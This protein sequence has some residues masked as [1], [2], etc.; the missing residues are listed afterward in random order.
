MKRAVAISLAVM[1]AFGLA[2]AAHSAS[3][4]NPD[5][6]VTLE[7]GSPLSFTVNYGGVIDDQANVVPGLTS[8]IQ[9]NFLGTS[10]NNTSYNFSYV[11]SNT[12]SGPINGSRVSIFGF[13]VSPNVASA[14]AS[15]LFTDEVFGGSFNTPN[16]GP[17]I[18]VCF[19]SGGGP[20]CTGGANGGVTLGNSGNGQFSLLFNN[21]PPGLDVTLGTFYVRYQS[22]DSGMLGLRGASASAIGAIVPEPA[23]WGMMIVGFG[24]VG[25]IARRRRAKSGLA[26]A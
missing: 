14:T 24:L 23:T 22:V 2:P 16:N 6:T 1:A 15:G 17:N 13:N 4:I 19:K 11:L 10:L 12:S 20:N 25:G 21:A 7:A 18:E 26:T 8:S 9:F 3:V 5:G